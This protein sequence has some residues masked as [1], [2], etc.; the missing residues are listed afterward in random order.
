[1]YIEF[2]AVCEDDFK[3]V[4]YAPSLFVA[5]VF[6]PPPHA[7]LSVFRQRSQMFGGADGPIRIAHFDFFG[8]FFLPFFSLFFQFFHGPFSYNCSLSKMRFRALLSSISS[9]FLCSLSPFCVSKHNVLSDY[10]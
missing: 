2:L 4:F 1:M 10:K 9:S 3:Q 8:T 5:L 7:S 6:S